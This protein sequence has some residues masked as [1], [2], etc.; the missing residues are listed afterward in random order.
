M[1]ASTRYRPHLSDVIAE[2]SV[3]VTNTG[4][5]SGDEVV[6][7]MVRLVFFFFF[8]FLCSMLP[9]EQSFHSLWIFAPLS[10][11]VHRI[12]RNV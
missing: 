5:V 3:E 7:V 9:I 1:I 8:S 2:V 4:D 12:T 10:R 11:E 6:L